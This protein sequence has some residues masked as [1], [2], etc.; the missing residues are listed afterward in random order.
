MIA[1]KRFMSAHRDYF[2]NIS[3]ILQL[4]IFGYNSCRNNIP[5]AFE[6]W[7]NEAPMSG[8][9]TFVSAHK[10]YFWLCDPSEKIYECS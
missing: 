6:S 3:L 9:K 1:Q 2:C 8:Q 4:L 7:K 10:G 5:L